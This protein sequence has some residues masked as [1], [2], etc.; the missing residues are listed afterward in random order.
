MVKIQHNK[1]RNLLFAEVFLARC[2]YI[3]HVGGVLKKIG[4]RATNREAQLA[5][6]IYVEKN[7]T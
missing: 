4:A 6:E 1:K 2:S 7:N 3:S 5:A